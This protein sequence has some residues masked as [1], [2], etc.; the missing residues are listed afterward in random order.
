[1][2]DAVGRELTFREDLSMEAEE[3]PLLEAVT[4]QLPVKTL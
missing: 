3:Y 4:R 2:T 1:V